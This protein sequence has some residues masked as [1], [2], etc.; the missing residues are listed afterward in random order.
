M[1]WFSHEF[2][3]RVMQ[4]DWNGSVEMFPCQTICLLIAI[5]SRDRVA[6]QRARERENNRRTATEVERKRRVR[7]SSH[8]RNSPEIVSTQSH[9][10]Y[11]ADLHGRSDLSTHSQINVPLVSWPV[12]FHD[13][14]KRPQKVFLES[15]VG[16]L[17][18]LQKLHGQLPE[19]VHS[20]NCH[21]FVGITAN[22]CRYKNMIE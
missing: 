8:V 14:L 13:V 21:I 19:R 15:E 4:T 2:T 9:S 22:L 18:L 7:V 10:V 3:G 12:L 6:T 17:P 5:R 1:K 20:E 11:T 16:Q